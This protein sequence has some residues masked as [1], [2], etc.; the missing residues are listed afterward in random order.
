MT[1]MVYFY[2]PKGTIN[3]ATQFYV[4]LIEKAFIKMRYRVQFYYVAFKTD[5]EK[6]IVTIRPGDFSKI[7][8]L[9][10]TNNIV[11]WF[12][13]IG[14]EEYRMLHGNSIRSYL[15]SKYL[16][17]LERK[18]LK[19][20]F[21][22][23]F[24]SEAMKRHYCE[25]YNLQILNDLVIPCYNK[26]LNSD[27]IISQDR[28][29][30]ELSFVYAG[31]LFAWQCIDRT[32]LIFKI[33]ESRFPKA[34]LTLLT[35][36]RLEAKRLIDKYSLKN[37]EV[38]YVKLEDLD[39]ELSKHKYG[40]LLRDKNSV[41]LVATPT[42]M[43]SYLS[44]GIIP[45]YT[46]VIDAFEENLDLGEFGVRVSFDSKDEEIA[47]SIL[48]HAGQDIS[49]A[50]IIQ[51]LEAVFGKFYNDDKYISSLV[52]MLKNKLLNEH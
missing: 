21:I 47:N 18:A 33:I 40:F 4:S 22:T 48:L 29:Y 20:S 9:N 31:G 24:V 35:G 23:L 16:E 15:V 14:P 39:V 36:D 46:N 34:K 25:K 44:V 45:I 3:D 13:G 41:N 10:P 28:K 30:K 8:R 42:K 7:R 26:H 52:S 38:S 1:K 6:I 49:P 19:G 32:L 51:K 11:T 50:E 37:V 2:L 17:R 12:Q 27:L 5:P 43:N